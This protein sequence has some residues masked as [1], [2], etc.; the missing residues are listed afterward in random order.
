MT[1]GTTEDE[2]RV[3]RKAIAILIAILSA[4]FL[5]RLFFYL[6]LP[7]DDFDLGTDQWLLTAKRWV[8]GDGYS[9]N[10]QKTPTAFR[11]PTVVCFFAGLLY[12]FQPDDPKWTILIG[13]WLLDVGTALLLYFVALE[14][15]K[16]K[17]AA[18]LASLMFAFYGPGAYFSLGGWSEP[19]YSFILVAFALTLLKA[20]RQPSAWRFGAVGVLLG[21]AALARPL[22]LYHPV[23]VLALMLWALRWNVPRVLRL[24]PCLLVAFCLVVT[25]WVIRN[26]LLFDAFIPGTT[27][28]GFALYN[29]NTGLGEDD[30]WRFRSSA[31]CRD[32]LWHELEEEFGPAPGVDDLSSY[33]AAKGIN[34]HE[35]DKFYKA[36]AIESI[37]SNPYRY[38]V[39]SLW[40]FIPFW[41]NVGY[42]RGEPPSLHTYIVLVANSCLLML[43]LSAFLFFRGEWVRR[44]VPLVALV[45]FTNAAYMAVIALVRY[46]V[47]LAP[48][49]M[50]FAAHTLVSLWDRR[51]VLRG[52]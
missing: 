1:P 42:G 27:S 8:A 40:R 47:P 2:T 49:L 22:S 36:S 14:V 48:L 5:F 26:F 28:G 50:V 25:P 12:A 45:I 33:L 35:A 13:Q 32:L 46:S 43:A 10:P 37:R 16:D 11:G 7:K 20:L 51:N 17:R 41:F 29:G 39:R 18:L 44:G 38:V 9:L 6:I 34:E 30:H 15:L 21:L 24:F 52:A 3:D 31:E 4:V 23:L 19:I